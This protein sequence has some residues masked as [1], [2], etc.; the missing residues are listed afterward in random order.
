[1]IFGIF[2][3]IFLGNS[4]GKLFYILYLFRKVLRLV[5]FF[6]VDMFIWSW[7]SLCSSIFLSSL[8]IHSHKEIL[9]SYCKDVDLYLVYIFQ[10]DQNKDFFEL[11]VDYEKL[12]SQIR[13]R[14][15]ENPLCLLPFALILPCLAN[16][17]LRVPSYPLQAEKWAF[18]RNNLSH[19]F[20][21]NFLRFKIKKMF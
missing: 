8:I 21:S 12:C 15:R 18:L 3:W 5:L 2:T 11:D 9:R 13:T 20:K 10:F 16:C 4:S 6:I 1:M 7:Y 17:S 19:H 14:D